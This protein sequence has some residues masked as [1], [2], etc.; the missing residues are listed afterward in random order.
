[1]SD[2]IQKTQLSL[3][4]LRKKRAEILTLA[5]KHGAYNVRVFG[6]VARGDSQPN[7]VDI[8]VSF[9]IGSSIFN[10]VGLWLDLQELLG[11]SVDLLTDH[12]EAGKITDIASREAVPL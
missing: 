6:S 4:M 7:D 11:C 1:M 9:Q 2:Q 5:E 8:L 3:E 12:P 10:Q